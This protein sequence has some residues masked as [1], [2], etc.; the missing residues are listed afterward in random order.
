MLDAA[1]VLVAFWGLSEEKSLEGGGWRGVL[2]EGEAYLRHD[3]GW[4]SEWSDTA[5]VI[6]SGSPVA[7]LGARCRER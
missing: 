3:A 2:G 6:D 7:R 5:R 4:L 1:S